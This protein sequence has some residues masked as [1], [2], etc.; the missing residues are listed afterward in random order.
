[1]DRPLVL[2]ASRRVGLTPD[3]YRATLVPHLLYQAGGSVPFERFRKAYWLLGCSHSSV[4]ASLSRV[5]DR[6]TKPGRTR[7]SIPASM[8]GPA[9]N[10]GS[11]TAARPWAASSP[12]TRTSARPPRSSAFCVGMR[13]RETNFGRS[14]LSAADPL[15]A[16][17]DDNQGEQDYT[18]L[19]GRREVRSPRLHQAPCLEPMQ[20]FGP[21]DLRFAA[22]ST[23]RL[24]Q[25][26][27]MTP[28]TIG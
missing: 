8:L 4:S 20:Q 15:S 27:F 17:K 7:R 6:G 19:R 11:A 25:M 22:A 14:R 12:S 3:R 18:S 24:T 9:T 13:R 5:P 1:M 23:V 16:V 2:P 26:S 10:A 28:V 21:V